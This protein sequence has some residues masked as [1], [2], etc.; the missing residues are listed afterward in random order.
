MTIVT[1]NAD[2]SAEAWEELYR[3]RIFEKLGV[4]NIFEAIV[5]ATNNK[6]I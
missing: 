4:G 6:L 2:E 5:A 1:T 3:Q